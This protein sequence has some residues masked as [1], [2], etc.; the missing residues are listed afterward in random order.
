MP[1]PSKALIVEDEMDIRELLTFILE[2]EGYEV[3]AAEDGAKGLE[4]AQ[5]VSPD[6]ILLDIMLPKMTGLEVCKALKNSTQTHSVPIIML[7]AKGEEEDIVQG[8]ELG[9]DDYIVKPFGPKVLLARIKA[10]LRRSLPNTGQ[11]KIDSNIVEAYEIKLDNERRRAYL[12]EQEVELTYS[13]FEILLTLM[14]NPGKVFT[15]GL[16]IDTIRGELHAITDRSVDVQIVGL[17]RK[18]G[19][20]GQYIET[21]RGV[22]YRFKD[23]N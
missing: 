23:L 1:G 18:L 9:A 14:K 5:K 20:F 7:T 4:M 2:R 17:R 8:L 19:G 12:D 22:G 6:I 15:R 10:M 16:I 21:V 3:Y 13:E 11:V